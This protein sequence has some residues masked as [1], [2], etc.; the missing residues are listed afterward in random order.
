MIRRVLTLLGT[1]LPTP[2]P[3]KVEPTLQAREPRPPFELPLSPGR[4]HRQPNCGFESTDPPSPVATD[5]L[6][7]GRIRSEA[8]EYLTE[9]SG[10]SSWLLHE[11]MGG[12]ALDLD[13]LPALSC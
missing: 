3:H 4:G 5:M 6:R 11:A 10:T 7:R 9:A 1:Y 2:M 13:L 8:G 12:S